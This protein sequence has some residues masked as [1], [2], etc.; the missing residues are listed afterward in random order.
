MIWKLHFKLAHIHII[1]LLG[2]IFVLERGDEF[3]LDFTVVKINIDPVFSLKEKSETT[4]RASRNLPTFSLS[5]KDGDLSVFKI[6]NRKVLV[7]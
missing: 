1:E 5:L 3:G 4:R 7:I 6:I 2:T